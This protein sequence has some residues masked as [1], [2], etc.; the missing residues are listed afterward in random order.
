MFENLYSSRLQRC[1]TLAGFIGH[2]VGRFLAS[3]PSRTRSNFDTHPKLRSARVYTAIIFAVVQASLCA[4]VLCGKRLVCHCELEGRCHADVLIAEFTHFF[5]ATGARSLLL[6]PHWNPHAFL[7]AARFLP[8]PF[9]DV[10]LDDNILQLCFDY[11]TKDPDVV[12]AQRLNFV[13]KW[14]ARP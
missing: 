13:K 2:V 1:C 3:L 11:V 9:Q 12:M 4:L 5:G 14:T 8:H 10:A 6:G 7:E